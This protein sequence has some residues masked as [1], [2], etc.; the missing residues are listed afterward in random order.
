MQEVI[1]PKTTENIEPVAVQK[2]LYKII[3][4]NDDVNTF[5]W[6]I[7]SL[8]DILDH[9]VEQAEQC[10]Y[11]IH[12]NGKC[13]VKSGELAKLKPLREGLTD[14]GIHAIIED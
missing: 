1:S 9:K 14:R 13:V 8:V 6:V 7:E 11:I 10:A 2:K 3:V 12:Y 4:L 5:D